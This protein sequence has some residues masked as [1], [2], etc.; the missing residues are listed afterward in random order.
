MK[1]NKLYAHEGV[2]KSPTEILKKN[3][4]NCKNILDPIFSF[5][6]GEGAITR[7]TVTQY[8][9]DCSEF[10]GTSKKGQKLITFL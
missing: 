9:K 1:K 7:K 4:D 8:I 3:E 2:V 10:N 5:D 6:Y